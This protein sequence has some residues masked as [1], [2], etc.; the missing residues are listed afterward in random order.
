[1]VAV[2]EA[3][4]AHAD[5]AAPV[6][7]AGGCVGHRVAGVAA[8]SAVGAV[9]GGLYLAAVAGHLV[10][11]GEAGV[12]PGHDAGP[13]GAAHLP[14]GHH[15]PAGVAAGAAVAHVDGAV[16]LAAVLG[17]HAAMQEAG[18]ARGRALAGLARAGAVA[19]RRADPAAAAA[20]P[21]IGRG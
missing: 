20:V 11:V 4:V 2:G 8:D 7:A 19:H 1:P 21:A 13:G 3:G 16:H 15:G 6:A 10:A 9:A 12:A 14:V 17:D 5:H 18:V